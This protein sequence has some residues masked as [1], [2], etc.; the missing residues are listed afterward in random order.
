V[1]YEND[2]G[3]FET[4]LFLY[5]HLNDIATAQRGAMGWGGDRYVAVNTP[6]GAGISWLTMW[7]TAVQAAQFRDLMERVIEKRFGTT[8]GS[9]GAGEMRRFTGKGRTLELVSAIVQ[10][11]PSVL[12]TDVPVGASTRIIDLAKVTLSTP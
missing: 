5:Q 10:G 7:D 9:G 6:Q 12:F 11:H 3:E 2:L 1:I 8:P 4:R